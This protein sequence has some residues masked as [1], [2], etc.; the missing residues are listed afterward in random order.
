MK[1]FKTMLPPFITGMTLALFL[2]SGC[3][4]ATTDD[5]MTETGTCTLTTPYKNND[6]F[7][8][9]LKYDTFP[10]S[11]SLEAP[12]ATTH[13]ATNDL[14]NN[15]EL[16]TTFDDDAN[17][18]LTSAVI[19]EKIK[20]PAGGNENVV[21]TIEKAGHTYRGQE[22]YNVKYTTDRHTNQDNYSG[23]ANCDIATHY[24]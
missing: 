18:H 16:N 19:H 6:K 20:I 17:I 23:T 9:K 1:Q 5:S 24:N 3:A 4:L 13:F 15:D 10:R 7:G 12:W 14:K 2:Y 22:V 8:W 11:K 21:L